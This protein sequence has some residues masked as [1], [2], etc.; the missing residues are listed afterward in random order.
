[1][2]TNTT[3]GDLT[4]ARS[5]LAHTARQSIPTLA[6]VC[7]RC[8]RTAAS[9][10]TAG[11]ERLCW[12]C[13]EQRQRDARGE[14]DDDEAER[15]SADLSAAADEIAASIDARTSGTVRIDGGAK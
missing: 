12:R 3:D 9:Y 5:V 13:Y 10:T 6:H 1:M 7:M 4:S 2:G 11:G 15:E 14:T 8:D